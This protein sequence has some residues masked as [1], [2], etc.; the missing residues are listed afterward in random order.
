[1]RQ[2]T[3][4]CYRNQYPYRWGMQPEC[5][6][7]RPTGPMGMWAAFWHSRAHALRRRHTSYMRRVKKA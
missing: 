6:H 7:A 4:E 1:M 2:Y 5:M 3:W